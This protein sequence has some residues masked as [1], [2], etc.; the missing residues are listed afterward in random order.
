MGRSGER[1]ACDVAGIRRDF[2]CL[3]KGLTGGTL[4][5]SAVLTTDIVYAAFYDDDSARYRPAARQRAPPRHDLGLGRA[6][7]RSAVLAPLSPRG[8]QARAVA[9][10]DR[11]D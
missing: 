1:F 4:P 11:P 7:R 9:A 2:I 3:S 6:D 8:A 5:L 10:A